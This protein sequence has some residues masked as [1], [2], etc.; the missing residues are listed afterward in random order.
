MRRL[1][2]FL[3]VFLCLLC[4]PGLIRP[5]GAAETEQG[6]AITRDLISYYFH[7]RDLASKEIEN[8]L[9]TLESLDPE[10]GRLW[11]QI[12]TDWAWVNE[13]MTVH[14]GILPDGLPEDDSLC[15]VVLGYGLEKNGDMKPELVDRLE[16]ALK[17]A[18]KYPE[19]YVLCTGGETANVP[20]ITEAG[21]MGNWLLAN[22]LSHNRL[23]L[24][25]EALSTTANA[26]NSCRILWR[27]YPQ[28]ESIAI[29]SSDYHIRWGVACF[30]TMIHMGRAK[31]SGEL[32]LVGNTS[33]ATESPNRDTMYSQAW[34]VSIITDVPFDSSYVPLLYMTD[35]VQETVATEP[36]PAPAALTDGEPLPAEPGTKEPVVPVLLGLAAVLLLLF[37][38]KKKRTDGSV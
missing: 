36:I 11:R 33:C 31:G 7:Y 9:Q 3:A 29:V 16:V 4:L 18:E 8:Q 19:S 22:G 28:V 6:R 20:G 26:Q 37:I 27:D 17:S 23:I 38:P 10:Q 2:R 21:Q 32:R 25:T 24:E 5:A 30:G 12:M 1:R 35:T 13:E 14:T 15:I 34:G